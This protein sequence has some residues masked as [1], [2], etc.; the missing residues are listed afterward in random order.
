MLGYADVN[1]SDSVSGLYMYR[2]AVCRAPAS[3]SNAPADRLMHATCCAW[4]S[5]PA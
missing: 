5:W 1:A 4:M 3:W 2:L